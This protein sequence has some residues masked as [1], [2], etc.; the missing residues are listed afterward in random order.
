MRRQ[1]VG[2]VHPAAHDERAH[3]APARGEPERGRDGGR[4]G[5]R[6]ES[7][8]GDRTP[9]RHRPPAPPAAVLHRHRGRGDRLRDGELRHRPPAHPRARRRGDAAAGDPRPGRPPPGAPVRG[10]AA[11]GR[12][13][14]GPRARTGS[15]A[16][17]R[18]ELEPV[19]RRRRE[20]RRRA[21]RAA[22]P[23]D[24]HRLERAPAPLPRPGRRPVRAARKGTDRP[25]MVRRAD[26][27]AIGR[28]PGRPRAAR[29]QSARDDDAARRRRARGEHCGRRAAGRRREAGSDSRMC[30]APS[31]DAPCSPSTTPSS[32]PG[33]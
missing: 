8:R 18:A 23:R 2:Q 11:A 21:P 9:D 29:H 1:R 20:P 31:G 12:R 22:P 26:P 6:G 28:R 24:H 19:G 33:G 4:S 17:G 25:R 15:A 32:P 7:A 5:R 30:A 3:P 27:R 16:P 13:R 10:D 14:R